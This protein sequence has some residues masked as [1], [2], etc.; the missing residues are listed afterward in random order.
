MATKLLFPSFLPQRRIPDEKKQQE[1]EQRV[2]R[3]ERTHNTYV[4]TG[5][6]SNERRNDFERSFFVI[7][8]LLLLFRHFDDRFSLIIFD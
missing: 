7:L 8:L 4:R 3:I 1:E 2:E 5:G 6:V